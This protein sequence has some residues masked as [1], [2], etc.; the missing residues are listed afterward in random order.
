MCCLELLLTNSLEVELDVYNPSSAGVKTGGASK[1]SVVYTLSSRPVRELS[2][3]GGEGCGQCLRNSR[4]HGPAR[5][6]TKEF[7][8]G[9]GHGKHPT[10][11]CSL[12]TG[13]T[14]VH[15]HVC[16]TQIGNRIP[17]IQEI[18][19]KGE[20]NKS[21]NKDSEKHWNKLQH[22]AMACPCAKHSLPLY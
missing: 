6:V 15:S 9:E 3:R 18:D 13:R 10:Q 16:E 11:T 12:Q 5:T 22:R 8:R 2:L 21:R 1:I 20:N 14:L 19:T 7:K 17:E 4:S